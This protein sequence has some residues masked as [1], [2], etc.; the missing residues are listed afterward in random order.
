[1]IL[2]DE[3]SLGKHNAGTLDMSLAACGTH[4]RGQIIYIKTP[5]SLIIGRK[6]TE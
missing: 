2:G 6:I 1:M 4:F 5:M 3:N